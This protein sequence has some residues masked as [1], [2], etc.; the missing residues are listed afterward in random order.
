MAPKAPSALSN[1]GAAGAEPLSNLGPEGAE[2]LSNLGAEGAELLSNLGAA[3]AEPLSNLGAFGAEPLTNDISKS[4]NILEV[5]D[6]PF[7]GINLKFGLRCDLL[8]II[9]NE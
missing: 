4:E 6:L 2:P 5:R 9:L 7:P 1:L 3:G 8:E